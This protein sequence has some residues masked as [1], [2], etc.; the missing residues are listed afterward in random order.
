MP[1]ARR[2]N[3]RST[4]ESLRELLESLVAFVPGPVANSRHVRMETRLS[5]TVAR[6]LFSIPRCALACALQQS[7]GG[8]FVELRCVARRESEAANGTAG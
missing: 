6:G 3:A 7:G 1:S 8:R 4:K 5:P 2:R